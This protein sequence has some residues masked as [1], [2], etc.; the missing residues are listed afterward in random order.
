MEEFLALCG[1]GIAFLGLSFLFNG[2][3]KIT[4]NRNYYDCEKKKK[5]NK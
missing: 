1:M 5:I 2:F 3:P 4:I